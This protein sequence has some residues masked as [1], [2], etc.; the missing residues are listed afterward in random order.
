MKQEKKVNRIPVMLR[1]P[2][3]VYAWLQ[4]KADKERRTVNAQATL[5]FEQLMAL[6]KPD[7]TVTQEPPQ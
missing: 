1:L 2:E 3:D 7:K 6:D 5:L 4:T